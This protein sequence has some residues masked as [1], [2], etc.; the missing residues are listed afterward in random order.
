MPVAIAET[1]ND[2]RMYFIPDYL[3]PNLGAGL[4]TSVMPFPPTN[5]PHA[6]DHPLFYRRPLCL[7]Q[8]GNRAGAELRPSQLQPSKF[9]P[10]KITNA[11]AYLLSSANLDTSKLN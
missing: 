10:G 8:L 3:D 2:S 1:S 9:R 5:R 4:C 6:T 11:N 7:L